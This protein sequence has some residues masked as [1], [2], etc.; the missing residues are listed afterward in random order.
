M[1]RTKLMLGVATLS[2]ALLGTGY[3][4][5]TDVLTIGGTVNTAD[6]DVDFEG[7]EMQPVG[8]EAT[9][10]QA[11]E[12]NDISTQV[13]NNTD[14]ATFTIDNLKPGLSVTHQIKMQNK[15][16][17]DAQLKSIKVEGVDTKIEE[18]KKQTNITVVVGDEEFSGT[19]ADFDHSAT[20]RNI[21]LADRENKEGDKVN[22]KVTIGIAE[23][24]FGGAE[25]SDT[26]KTT[27]GFDLKF[28]W[29]QTGVQP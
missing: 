4:A 29:E 20:E 18:L 21:V 16:T 11:Y 7:T 26:T 22:V 24:A 25:A 3:A 12:I 15:G 23:G 6:F 5:M 27:I 10:P 19:L 9:N 14:R 1:K 2:A 17:I 13:D 28:N 8:D